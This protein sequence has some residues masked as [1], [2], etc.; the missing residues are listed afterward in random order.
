VK[1][2]GGAVADWLGFLAYERGLSPRT[3]RAYADDLRALARHL[4]APEDAWPDWTA[5]GT[6]QL[7]GFLE[8]MRREGMSESTRARRLVAVKGFFAHLRSE[9]KIASD[10]AAALVQARRTRVLPHALPQAAVGGMLDEADAAASGGGTAETD[11]RD[12]AGASRA[13]RDALR[14]AAILE[15]LYGCGLRVSELAGLPLDAVRF[16][17]ALVRVRGKGS[18]ERLVPLG[19][20]AEE[21]LRA[22]LRDARPLYRPAP[23]EPRLFLNRFGRGLTRTTVWTL[24]KRHAARAGLP[25]GT[26][27][28]WMRHSFATH[29]M[30]N[31]APVRVI[32]EM[33]GHADVGTTQIYTHVDA[34]R[35]SSVVRSFHPRG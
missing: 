18:K 3:R 31:G 7:L 25:A 4:G 12:P 23:G 19:G 33:L 1:A 32:Q 26:S 9:E 11:A 15:L 29:L 16:D 30:G 20:R 27:P 34:G 13:R 2:N 8:A 21:A 5:V 17:E 10:P 14:D 6:P 24:V 22:Y 35:L 28:H